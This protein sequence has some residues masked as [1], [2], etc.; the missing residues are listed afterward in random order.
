MGAGPRALLLHGTGASTHSWAGLFPMLAAHYD[1]LAIDLPGHGFSQMRPGFVPSLP[2]VTMA[3][4]RVLKELDF[5]PKVIIGHSAGAAIAINLAKRNPADLERIVSLNGALQPF[6]GAMGIIAPMTAKLVTF[7]GFAARAL[8]SSAK[9]IG[10]VERLLLDT[11][12][13]PSRETLEQYAVLMRSREHVQGTLQMMAN[14]DLSPMEAICA[15][16]DRPILFVTGSKDRTVP[17]DT[18]L[19]LSKIARNGRYLCIEDVG[20]LAHEEAPA[21]LATAILNH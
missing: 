20:H 9:D 21:K 13:V 18:A 1:L 15:E 7:G 2:N 12:S 16:L 14:W 19:D 11:G 6:A 10:R 8:S 4:S 5:W 17:P 3:I